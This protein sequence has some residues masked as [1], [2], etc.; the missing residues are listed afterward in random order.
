[1]TPA[2]IFF[3]N[4]ERNKRAVKIPT[5]NILSEVDDTIKKFGYS[6]IV[7]HPQDFVSTDQNGQVVSSGLDVSQLRD[8]SQLLDQILSS[9]IRIV[10][11]EKLINL[12]P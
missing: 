7:F 12:T 1:M 6:V 11:F 2:M 4:N 9:V 8:L 10:I 3:K 5:K